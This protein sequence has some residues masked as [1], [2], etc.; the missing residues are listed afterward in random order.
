MNRFLERIKRLKDVVIHPTSL[1]YPNTWSHSVYLKYLRDRGAKIGE[2]TRF[3]SPN[4]CTI[5]PGRLDYIEIGDNCAF[6]GVS[7]LAH[8]YSWYTL[9]GSCN[10]LLPD[11]GGRVVIGNNCF[12]GYQALILKG[13]TI[14]DNVIIGAR[15]VVKGNV[16]SNTVWA[17][18]P[19]RQ[20]CTIEEFYQKKV[21]C[22]IEDAFYRRDHIRKIKGR[23]PQISEMGMFA[24]LFL[25]RT[26]ENY[27]KYI[28][29]IEF[30]GKKD[31]EMVRNYFYQSSPLFHSFEEFLKG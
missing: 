23:D 8:D 22:R 18:V 7:I 26:K 20:I 30:N 17:G 4:R 3:V 15:S 16:P 31:V 21:K 6:S 27:D 10:D 19:A 24:C 2:N 13:T 11:P 9:L 5:D 25:E 1:L 14:G 12:I 28:K 29:D